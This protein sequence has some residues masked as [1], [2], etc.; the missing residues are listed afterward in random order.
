MTIPRHA[1]RPG[2][3]EV[4]GRLTW[5]ATVAIQ[6]AILAGAAGLLAAIW[7]GVTI[8]RWVLTVDCAVIIG[9]AL[10]TGRPP[11]GEQI[12]RAVMTH[13]DGSGR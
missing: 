10:T 1:H 11:T 3:P 2:R 8:P 7:T 4:F 12:A 5:G 13:P 6:L 9:Y